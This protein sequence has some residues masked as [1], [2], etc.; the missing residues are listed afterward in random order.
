MNQSQETSKAFSE[1]VIHEIEL[2][3]KFKHQDFK[4]FLL[5]YANV[6]LE[7]HEKVIGLI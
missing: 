5:D 1:Q 3:S 7:F 6:Q 4:K 2:F